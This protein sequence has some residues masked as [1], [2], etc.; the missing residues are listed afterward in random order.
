MARVIRC[1]ANGCH[2]MVKLPKHYCEV[3]KDQEREYK[4]RDKT[5]T[6]RY[7][8]VV[9]NRDG[10]KSSQYQFY[11]T[12]QWVALRQATLNNQHYLC[13]YCKVQGRVTATKIVDHIVP[14]EVDQTLKANPSNLAVVCPSCHA[15]KT[16][17][18]QRYYGTGKDN[19][20]KPVRATNNIAA[21]VKMMNDV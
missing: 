11:R 9:R 13:Q 21:I 14:I 6:H 7:N 16:R 8:T 19:W 4:P 20:L 2:T 1:R 18:E 12:R 3:H 15:A 5:A 17:W 10:N